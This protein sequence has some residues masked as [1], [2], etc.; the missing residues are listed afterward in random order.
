M[1][2]EEVSEDCKKLHNKE[3]H[4]LY[5]PQNLTHVNKYKRMGCKANVAQMG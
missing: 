4:D 2:M 1:Q 3:F 5:C